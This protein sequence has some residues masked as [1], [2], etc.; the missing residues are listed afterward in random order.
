MSLLN[1]FS[2]LWTRFTTKWKLKDKIILGLVIP[3]ESWQRKLEQIVKTIKCNFWKWLFMPSLMLKPKNPIF[4]ISCDFEKLNFGLP[5]LQYTVMFSQSI[6]VDQFCNC[7]KKDSIFP[8]SSCLV[9]RCTVFPSSFFSG[10]LFSYL[11]QHS[12]TCR[13]ASES[14]HFPI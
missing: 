5:W 9:S 3:D 1:K 7:S 12:W 4:K 2:Q 11:L 14:D 13:I 8:S 10:F 6:P